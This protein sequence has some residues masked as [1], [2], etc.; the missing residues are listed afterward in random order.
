M[1]IEEIRER[2]ASHR[3]LLDSLRVASLSLFGSG[4]RGE[5]RPE[6]DLD[7]LVEFN[8][9]VGLLAFVRLKNTLEEILD[10]P[11]DLVTMDALTPAVRER[12]LKE[13]IR[14]A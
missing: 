9:P 7:F 5:L 12:V 8:G 13:A 4:A 11:V 10:R 2:L 14:A 1:T 3:E 6:S